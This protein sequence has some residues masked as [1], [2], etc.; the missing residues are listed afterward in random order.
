MKELPPG[1]KAYKRTPLFTEATVPAGLLKDHSTKEGTWGLIHV[2]TGTLRYC[3]TDPRRAPSRV[4]LAAG[5][6]PGVVEPTIIH[7]VEPLG[8]VEFWVEFHR[9]MQ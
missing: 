7:K 4:D 9:P 2:E 5:E 6:Q 1:F 3:I 8:P